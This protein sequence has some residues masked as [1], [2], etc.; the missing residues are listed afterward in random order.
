[1]R[2][3]RFIAAS[4]CL[5]PYVLTFVHDGGGMTGVWGRVARALHFFVLRVRT[6]ATLSATSWPRRC[7]SNRVTVG[8]P[9][10]VSAQ[11]MMRCVERV[12]CRDQPICGSLSW[13][14][15]Y[16]AMTFG[17]RLSL[18]SSNFS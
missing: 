16:A 14:A 17:G 2:G 9:R 4:A 6:G 15:A 1:M 13:V 3:K 10:Q 5:G 7:V 12:P 11:Q 18:P 8:H